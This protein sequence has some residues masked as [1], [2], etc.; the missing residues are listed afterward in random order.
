MNNCL[1]KNTTKRSL[2]LAFSVSC[3]ILSSCSVENILQ[4]NTNS[5]NNV[6]RVGKSN[7]SLSI[8][9]KP[10]K[11][12][13]VVKKTQN[14][15]LPYT[16]VEVKSYKIYLIK[17]NNA[18]FPSGGDPLDPSK[19][20]YTLTSNVDYESGAFVTFSG[21]SGSNGD[22][23]HVAVRAYDG[24]NAT[25]NELIK[26][27]NGSSTPWSGTAL[28]TPRVAV[29]TSGVK[30]DNDSLSVSTTTPLQVSPN[31]I[32]GKGAIIDIDI[33]PL[34]Q[35]T[36]KIKSYKVNLTIDPK[37]PDLTKVYTTSYTVLRDNSQLTNSGVHK[38]LIDTPPDYATYN[39]TVEAFDINGNSLIIANNNGTTYTF[40]DNN[41]QIAVSSNRATVARNF[42]V[43]ISGNKFSIDAN[44]RNYLIKTSSGNG[45]SGSGGDNGQSTSA[46][47]QF[48]SPSDITQDSLG[49]IYI[50][51]SG[52]NRIR[53][54]STSGVITTFAGGGTST[55]ESV[56][57]TT[58]QLNNPSSV[59]VDVLGSVYISDSGN[60]KIRK[61]DTSGVIT[62][63][64]GGGLSTGEN[65]QATDAQL[66]NPTGLF[67]DKNNNVYF[68]DSG[69]NRIKKIN[70]SNDISTIVGTNS[71]LNNPTDLFVDEDSNI[72]I[73]DKGNYRIKKFDSSD[74]SLTN[75][76]GSGVICPDSICGDGGDAT[77]ATFT[78]P[79][80]ISLDPW[81]NIY[82][83]D[84]SKVR[85]VNSIDKKI[86]TFAG[87]TSSSYSGENT[88]ATL[89]GL[90]SKGIFASNSGDIFFTDSLNNRIRLLF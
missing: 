67:V 14:G 24:L 42:S 51:D 63:V 65:I 83:S 50:A 56:Q 90:Y 5:V 61:V 78:S 11:N 7:N 21:L 3:V 31:L 2:F 79:S 41:K 27:N 49:N 1:N 29:S 8:N 20:I 13:F 73:T 64:A 66:S 62:T 17:N 81:N 16:Y 9:I 43:S 59:F 33:K 34:G 68:A 54:I 58:A 74:L 30:I 87:T 15:L 36:R 39:A 88:D 80:N 47:V 53:K 70:T 48:N 84:G 46:T 71:E 23:Y 44:L 28:L 35:T 85:L 77:S 37:L 57:A 12:S 4:T 6:I 22:Y 86:S 82:V 18:I 32:D 75:I 76:A 55:D 19:V 69:T 38:V 26:E 52:N 60:N 25:G 10:I 40:P 45:T 89:G 72:Y